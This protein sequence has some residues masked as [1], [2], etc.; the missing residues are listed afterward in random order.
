MF[1]DIS[2]LPPHVKYNRLFLH[3]HPKYHPVKNIKPKPKPK[4]TKTCA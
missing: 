3:P 1:F 2:L 4:Q